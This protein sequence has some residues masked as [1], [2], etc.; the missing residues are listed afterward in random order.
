MLATAGVP[1]LAL[2]LLNLGG[3]VGKQRVSSV[4][5]PASKQR[6]AVSIL[7][8]AVVLAPVGHVRVGPGVADAAHAG[9]RGVGQLS[10]AATAATVATAVTRVTGAAGNLLLGEHW[11]LAGGQSDVGLDGLC[12]SMRP[13]VCVSGGSVQRERVVSCMALVL[14]VSPAGAALALVLDASQHAA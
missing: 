7:H 5:V 10:D 3:W 1:F 4:A 6:R 8:A 14:S 11:Q 13:V 2:V 12:S 9:D